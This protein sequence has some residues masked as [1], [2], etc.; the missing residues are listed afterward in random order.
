MESYHNLSFEEEPIVRVNQDG[1]LE[2]KCIYGEYNSAT[3]LCK[4][5]GKKDKNSSWCMGTLA[6]AVVIAL[7]F[8]WFLTSMIR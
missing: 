8:A 7:A 2:R 6:L 4:A 5:S 1:A 3:K